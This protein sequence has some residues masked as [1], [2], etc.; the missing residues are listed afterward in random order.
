MLGSFEKALV[1]FKKKLFH[2]PS[3]DQKMVSKVGNDDFGKQTIENFNSNGVDT[4]HLFICEDNSIPSGVASI[5]VDSKTGKNVI[6]VV[7]GSNFAITSNEISSTLN[8]IL[9]SQSG[10]TVVITQLEIPMGLVEQ[11]LKTSSAVKN[12]ITILNPAPAAKLSDVKLF[13]IIISVT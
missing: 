2:K 8:Q 11:T 1:F 5:L 12:V 7:P 9:P 3:I 4:R 10:I 13:R 6:V